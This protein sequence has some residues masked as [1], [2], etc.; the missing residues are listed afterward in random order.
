MGNFWIIRGVWFCDDI[1]CVKCLILFL[2]KM[3]VEGEILEEKIRSFLLD[4]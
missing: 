1:Y 3:I 4:F 2:N